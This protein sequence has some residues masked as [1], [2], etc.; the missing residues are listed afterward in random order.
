MLLIVEVGS[1]LW[2]EEGQERMIE[3]EKF[4][5]EVVDILFG[6][7]NVLQLVS[8]SRHVVVSSPLEV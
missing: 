1:L 6:Q 2:V 3:G 4:V 7:L 5:E 8:I